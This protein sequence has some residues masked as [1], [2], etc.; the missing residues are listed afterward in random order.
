MLIFLSLEITHKVTFSQM[1]NG[2]S[3]YTNTSDSVVEILS[4]V[5]QTDQTV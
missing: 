5:N 2:Q 3:K 1:F 4:Q